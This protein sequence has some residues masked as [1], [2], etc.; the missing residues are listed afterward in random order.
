MA[1]LE[2]RY[3]KK[4]VLIYYSY[5][6]I[7]G[8]KQKPFHTTDFKTHKKQLKAARELE[9][10]T[11]AGVS[12]KKDFK[13][14]TF[15]E[16]KNKYLEHELDYN[17][18]NTYKRAVVFFRSFLS[19]MPIID[20]SEFNIQNL[21]IWH[22]ERSKSV[23]ETTINKE[24]TILQS[25]SSFCI[26]EDILKDNVARSLERYTETDTDKKDFI[27][28]EDVSRAIVYSKIPRGM[29]YQRE[30][31]KQW[32]GKQ[33]HSAVMAAWY[34]GLRR[35]EIANLDLWKDFDTVNHKVHVH[36]KIDPVTGRK[37]KIKGKKERTV[38]VDPAF[39]AHVEVLRKENQSSYYVYNKACGP[40]GLDI[41]S[42]IVKEF[43]KF[44]DIRTAI[45]K[46]I[47]G[48]HNIRHSFGTYLLHNGASPRDVMEAMGHKSIL[49]TMIYAHTAER[50]LKAAISKLP[51]L[52]SITTVPIIPKGKH[53]APPAPQ[54]PFSDK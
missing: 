21:K 44:Y 52:P 6:R 45:S 29:K 49:T 7:H 24:I 36:T 50:Y 27:F 37:W 47:A 43:C 23:A 20:M 53:P 17:S 12:I 18:I 54:Q 51:K 28:L 31:T 25:F 8:K 10:L 39:S 16:A 41:L 3:S 35:G 13:D 32:N 1:W 46:E 42:R 38:D 48:L 15:E 2:K 4:G 9:D 22:K 19:I 14:I 33:V 34:A 11:A 30:S 40:I 26:E 5:Y